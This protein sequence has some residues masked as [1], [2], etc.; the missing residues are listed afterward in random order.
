MSGP[1]FEEILAAVSAASAGKPGGRVPLPA[2]PRGGGLAAQLAAAVNLLLD[3][4]EERTAG[5]EA[6]LRSAQAESE[7]LLAER[8]ERWRQSE[9][10]F[11][12]AFQASPAAISIASLPEGRWIE[13]NDAHA[14]LIGYSNEELIGRTSAEMELVDPAEREKILR[15]IREK[16]RLRDV[17]IRVRT[18]SG[19]YRE[20]LLSVEQVELEGKPCA[21]TIQYDITEIKRAER[22]VR[23]LNSDLESGKAALE[24][25][26]RD[27]QAFSYSVAH[28][29]RAPLRSIDA[30]SKMIV[31][32]Y[33]D[34][35]D[36][37]GTDH[38]KH[39]RDSAQRMA[40]LIDDLL[41]LSRVT[42]IEMSRAPIDLSAM[43]RAI[44]ERLQWEEPGRRVE[45]EVPEGILANG[46]ARLLGI[47]LENLIGNAWKFTA[48][49]LA[50][51]I[52]IGARSG[53]GERTY[54]V[55]DNGAGFDMAYANK[56]FGVFQRLHKTA[57]FEGTGI[58]LATVERVI[59]RHGGRVWGEGKVGLGATFHFTLGE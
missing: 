49:R 4:Q 2:D 51:R 47:A 24:A 52:E 26:N 37:A 35:L 45:W 1:T 57:E 20:V 44:L 11:A 42:Q 54:F 33:A 55:R 36:A 59:R 17:E 6:A 28:D 18:K 15:A 23:R 38:L 50:A 12:K 30:F 25:A 53:E 10:K 31:D 58:G 16:G 19:E 39:I 7:R 40:A 43:A 8:T 13:I 48:N 14:K 46:D 32:G 21:L 22:E 41:T 9:A 3:R 29:L 34:R 27:L 56:L 5:L